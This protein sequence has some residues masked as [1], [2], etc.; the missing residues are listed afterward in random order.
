M[1]KVK[2][3]KDVNNKDIVPAD[4]ETANMLFILIKNPGI[5]KDIDSMPL[6]R[7]LYNRI[8]SGIRALF[9]LEVVLFCSHLSQGNPG[10]AVMWAWTLVKNKICNMDDLVYSFPYGFPTWD[11]FNEIWDAQKDTATGKNILDTEEPWTEALE[12]YKF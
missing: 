3:M 5:I 1:D 11:A 9:T 10:C 4:E 8:P 2:C 7:I 12:K 6:A